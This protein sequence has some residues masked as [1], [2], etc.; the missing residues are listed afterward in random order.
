[1]ATS[2]EIDL[3]LTVTRE[4]MEDLAL[5]DP[6]N[7]YELVNTGPGMRTWR[8][9][10]VE[11]T[12]V[13]GRTLLNAVLETR[14]MPLVVRVMGDTWQEVATRAQVMFDAVSQ[15]VYLA[16]LTMDDVVY[17]FVCEPADIAISG[18]DTWDKHRVMACQQ[19]YVLSIPYDP[20][21]VGLS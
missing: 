6:A 21:K 1:M 10:Y 8:R 9:D 5:E 14:T 4:G 19:E 16:T 13:H 15:F 18:Q 17:Y 20:L 12:Y 11:G 3:A 2:N 7:G